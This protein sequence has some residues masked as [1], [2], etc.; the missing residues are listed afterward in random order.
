[1][2]HSGRAL[3]G[4]QTFP[5]ENGFRRWRSASRRCR[6]RQSAAVS[7]LAALDRTLPGTG[8]GGPFC[9]GDRSPDH[10]LAALVRVLRLSQYLQAV[11]SGDRDRVL[12]SLLLLLQGAAGE[13]FLL[14]DFYPAF[15]RFAPA[16][17]S[18][19]CLFRGLRR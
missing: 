3:G 13:F 14:S 19:R 16:S 1:M 9:G 7:D 6:I 12:E 18:V 4:H 11:V 15:Q 17:N 8:L 2:L 5:N 10:W